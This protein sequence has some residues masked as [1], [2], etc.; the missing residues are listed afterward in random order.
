MVQFAELEMKS[1]GKG[2]QEGREESRENTSL[3][4]ITTLKLLKSNMG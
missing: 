1:R 4:V 2:E 3:K